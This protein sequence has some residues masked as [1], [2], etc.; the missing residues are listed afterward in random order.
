MEIWRA[1]CKGAAEPDTAWKTV[2][3]KIY[4]ERRHATSAMKYGRGSMSYDYQENMWVSNDGRW[5]YR[6][7]KATIEDEEW[8]NV[9][10][11]K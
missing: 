10:P 3:N 2:N 6:V 8:E 5:V 9:P 11:K 7:V 4:L 1:V